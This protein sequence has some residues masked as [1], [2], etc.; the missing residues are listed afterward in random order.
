MAKIGL[1]NIYVAKIMSESPEATTYDTP[2]KI[3]K[4]MNAN[5]TP[6]TSSAI[7]YGDD[8]AQEIIEDLEG[9]EVS[10]AINNLSME[11]YA[12]VMGKT[13]DANGGVL[14]SQE[15]EAPYVA[16]G[17]EVPLSKGGKRMTWLYKGKFVTPTE[18]DATKQGATTFQTP[19]ITGSF[20]TRED[21][22]W[23][24]RV[25]SNETNTAIVNSW[26]SDVVEAPAPP[27]APEV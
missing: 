23:R 24:Y 14:D 8:A 16:L 12:Y 9:I 1:K 22:R 2:R 5:V 10:V 13:L 3:S 4:A 27:V 7:L 20:I 26:F 25:D 18:E 21:G 15:D 6:T 17:Y 19:T 11:D